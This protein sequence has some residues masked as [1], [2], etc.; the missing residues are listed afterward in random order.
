[1]IEEHNY[2]DFFANAEEDIVDNERLGQLNN[3]ISRRKVLLDEKEG[4]DA[5]LKKLN[6]ELLDIETRQIPE[7]MDNAGVAEFTTKDGFKV[8]VKPFVSAI[9]A[10]YKE[11]AFQWFDDNGLSSII[12]RTVSLK[13]DKKQ[14]ELATMAEDRLRD[15]GFEP[16]TKLDI[17]YQTFQA[18]VKELHEKGIMPPLHE[19]GVYFGRRATVRKK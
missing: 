18:T 14:A 9:P 5:Q 10:N 6:E 17:A 11:E 16:E 1:M 19:W 12:K 7:V 4:L 3:L 13:F 8:G 15:L 2:D